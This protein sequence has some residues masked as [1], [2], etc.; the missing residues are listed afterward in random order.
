MHGVSGCA[1]QQQTQALRQHQRTLLQP[2]SRPSSSAVL[3]TVWRSAAAAAVAVVAMSAVAQRQT[4]QPGVCVCVCVPQVIKGWLIQRRQLE[5]CTVHKGEG[6]LMIWAA[7]C[8]R[9][10]LAAPHTH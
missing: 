3:F 2:L 1:A 5:S 8:G 9:S 7:L 4:R 10:L 6:E